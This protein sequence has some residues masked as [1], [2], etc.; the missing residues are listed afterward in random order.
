[1]PPQESPSDPKNIKYVDDL[2]VF[3]IDPKTSAFFETD[4][5]AR[6]R[7]SREGC[8]DK[9]GID[10]VHDPK[11]DAELSEGSRSSSTAKKKRGDDPASGNKPA[12]ALG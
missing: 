4:R 2:V 1:M 5:I 10:A 3:P 6:E 11:R 12:A 8:D 7:G 9:D